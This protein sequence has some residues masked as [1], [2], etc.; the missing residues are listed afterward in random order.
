MKQ[1]VVV[2]RDHPRTARIEIEGKLARMSICLI[3]LW[4]TMRCLSSV[5]VISTFLRRFWWGRKS[6]RP[7]IER[8]QDYAIYIYRWLKPR[9]PADPDS[10]FCYEPVDEEED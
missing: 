7:D 10:D 3:V 2:V 6:P 1:K 9:L 8:L 4:I 5:D